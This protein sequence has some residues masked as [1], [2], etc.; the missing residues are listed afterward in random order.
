VDKNAFVSN[1]RFG[2]LVVDDDS[3]SSSIILNT[4]DDPKNR[5]YICKLIYSPIN[6]KKLIKNSATIQIKNE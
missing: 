2:P 1:N 6:T 5:E 4:E 3:D